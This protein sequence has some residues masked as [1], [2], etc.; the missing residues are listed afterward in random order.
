MFQKLINIAR[1]LL[2][3]LVMVGL[4]FWGYKAVALVVVTTIFN[5]LTL[6]INYI[7]CKRKLRVK[8]YFKRFK[9]GFLK[10]VSIY[11][12]WIFLNAIMDR[13]FWSSGQFIL[14]ILSR[15]GI[16]GGVCG[17]YPVEGYVFP[18]FHRYQ[19]R[20]ST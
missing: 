20:V 9:W 8:L 5:V 3:P 11:S 4:L 10:E 6:S 7:Y 1:T 17:R 12:F 2:N 15:D 13:I 18:V 16:R 19:L 14:G